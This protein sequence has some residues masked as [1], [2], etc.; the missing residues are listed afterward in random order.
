M[1]D[2]ISEVESMKMPLVSIV[3]ATYRR[4]QELAAA[5]LS[6]SKQDYPSLELVLIDDNDEATWNNRV[7]EIIGEFQ[8]ASP[9]KPLLYAANHPNQGSAGA[10]NVG[11]HMAHGEYITFLD[12]DDIYLPEKVSRQLQAMLSSNADYCLTDLELFNE[13]GKLIDRRRHSYLLG[14]SSDSLLQCH[15]MYHMTGTD[16]MMFRREYL[17]QIGGFPSIDQ[18]DE[19]Y[20]MKEAISGGGK[21]CYLPCCDV[22]AYVH[23][24]ENGLSSGEKKIAGENQLYRFKQIFFD[25]I[26]AKSRRYIKMRH[27]AVLA[28]AELRRQKYPAFFINGVCSF[29]SAPIACIQLLLRRRGA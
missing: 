21:L 6:L 25:R 16:T 28:F 15:L 19:F 13:Q 18:G 9:D 29:L 1:R 22:R 17:V 26:N 24:G 11:I 3:I 7:M 4:D 23:T 14:A 8:K 5:L 27:Y 10:R 20:L 12:D 2:E